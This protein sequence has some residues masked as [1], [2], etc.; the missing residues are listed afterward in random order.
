[1]VVEV[2]PISNQAADMLQRFEPVSMH[3]LPL[4]RT[5]HPLDQATLL[6]AVRSDEFLT[7]AIASDPGREAAAGEDVDFY[8]EVTH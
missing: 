3:A 1:M 7:Q 4:A 5:N 6:G 2:D 8:P